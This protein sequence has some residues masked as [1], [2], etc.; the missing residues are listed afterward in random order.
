MASLAAQ[1]GPYGHPWGPSQGTHDIHPLEG[2]QMTACQ[3]EREGEREA[4]EAIKPVSTFSL[5]EFS[6]TY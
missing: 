4:A 2:S 1:V 3:S 5:I 6:I